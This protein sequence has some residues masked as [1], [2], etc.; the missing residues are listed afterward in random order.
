MAYMNQEKKRK[1]NEALKPVL[2][3]YGVKG[4]LGVQH[5]STLVLNI[6]EGPIDFIKDYNNTAT[7]R[8]GSEHV[9]AEDYINVNQYHYQKHFSGKALEFFKEVLPILNKENYDNSNSQIDYFDVGYWLEVNIGRWDKP[10]K[11][12]GE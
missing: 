1:I 4:R 2:K 12:T 11:F 10:Y 6:T 8:Y 7:E 9:T 3:K 5:H